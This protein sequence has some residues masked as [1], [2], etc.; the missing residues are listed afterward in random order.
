MGTAPLK[1]MK[2][3][4]IVLDLTTELTRV[5]APHRAKFSKV[6]I[7]N[8][9]GTKFKELE[10]LEE[11]GINFLS[12]NW[13]IPG[14][15]NFKPYAMKLANSIIQK[16][17]GGTKYWFESARVLLTSATMTECKYSENPNLA[18]VARMLARDITGYAR[19]MLEYGN[20]TNDEWLKDNWSRWG[21]PDADDM[22]SM[23]DV[24]EHCR[25]DIDA[26]TLPV[27][28]RCMSSDDIDF[29]HCMYEP[30]TIYIM[31]P[32]SQI[33]EL[34]P[35]LRTV[36][37][38]ANAQIL[39]L[40]GAGPLRTELMIDEAYQLHTEELDHGLT[41][42]R[43]FGLDITLCYNDLQQVQ[44]LYPKTYSSMIGSCGILQV[45]NVNRDSATAEHLSKL[46]GEREVLTVNRSINT[47]P[48]DEAQDKFGV[49]DGKSISTRRLILPHEIQSLKKHEQIM[50]VPGI[51]NPIR[52]NK[53]RYLDV[54]KL[55][56]RAMPNP[57]YSKK[58]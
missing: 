50:W 22:K 35:F 38:H 14:S 1:Y 54:P 10:G 41:S 36:A 32:M 31:A 30:T 28:M 17:H 13:M 46:C 16:E 52:C 44:A 23:K 8:L 26:F 7:V 11:V 18:N 6:K 45:L 48:L 21:R 12:R 5:T 37:A 33:E 34:T 20:A 40:E 42:V 9:T 43:K 55:A 47:D 19:Q 3:S 57:M 56:K 27:V 25:T 29:R 24:Q 15:D 53:K 51:F 4:E 49:S 39:S 2:K 58:G